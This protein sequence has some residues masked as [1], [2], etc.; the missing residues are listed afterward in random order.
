MQYIDINELHEWELNPRFVNKKDFEA[1]K[2]DLK[3]DIAKEF[4]EARPIIVSDRTGKYVIIAG[5]TRYKASK[6]LGFKSVPVAVIHD[7]TE[8]QE[9]EIN[10][11]DNTHR[12]QFDFD[13]IANHFDPIEFEEWGGFIAGFDSSFELQEEEGKQEHEERKDGEEIQGIEKESEFNLLID[14]VTNIKGLEQRNNFLFESGYEGDTESLTNSPAITEIIARL[15]SARSASAM[16]ILSNDC[17]G[18]ILEINPQNNHL[19]LFAN[20]LDL[21]YNTN[22][23]KCEPLEIEKHFNSIDFIYTNYNNIS[24]NYNTEIGYIERL[25]YKIILTLENNRFFVVK[26]KEQEGKDGAIMPTVADFLKSAEMHGT[27]LYNHLIF[28]KEGHTKLKTLESKR[29]LRNE[30]IHVLCFFKG[31]TAKIKDI[32]AKLS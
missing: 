8:K 16:K 28:F 15:F 11:K 5:N 2:K 9:Q 29:K 19:Q 13:M 7:L 25:V 20:E 4:F 14:S 3:S 24:K 22:T 21:Q 12:G 1:L 6:E 17:T 10:I 23:E 31:N 27:C 30:K 26:I 32:Y 18:T